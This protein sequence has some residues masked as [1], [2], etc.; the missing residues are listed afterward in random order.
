MTSAKV[1][2]SAI[3]GFINLLCNNLGNYEIK[4]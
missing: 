4:Y 1:T 2:N 3:T